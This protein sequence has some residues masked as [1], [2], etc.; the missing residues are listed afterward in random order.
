MSH[1]WQV[2]ER[3]RAISASH[4][5]EWQ[6][7]TNAQATTRTFHDRHIQPGKNHRRVRACCG[8]HCGCQMPHSANDA[9]QGHDC[10]QIESRAGTAMSQMQN[11]IRLGD[12]ELDRSID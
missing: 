2:A 12:S 3:I 10:Q 8:G 9:S 6:Q 11:Q 7:V 4:V 5:R 1:G